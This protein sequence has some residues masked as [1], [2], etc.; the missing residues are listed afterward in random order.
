ML[1]VTPEEKFAI[2]A[3]GRAPIQLSASSGEIP[4]D[5][6]FLQLSLEIRA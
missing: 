3:R 5:D 6:G 4:A 2:R 1:W